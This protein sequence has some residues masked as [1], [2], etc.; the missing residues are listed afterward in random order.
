MPVRN[1]QCS[2]FI[3]TSRASL[4]EGL[5]SKPEFMGFILPMEAGEIASFLIKTLRIPAGDNLR[6]SCS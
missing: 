4:F 6:H 3:I 1:S 2:A 5:R